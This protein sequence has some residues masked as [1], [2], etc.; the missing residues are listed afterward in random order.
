MQTSLLE[1]AT[2][3]LLL[4]VAVVVGLFLRGGILIAGSRTAAAAAVV[5]AWMAYSG[6]L[7]AQRDAA[8]S[9]FGPPALDP[10]PG[11]GASAGLHRR[12]QSDSARA[13]RNT[14]VTHPSSGSTPSACPWKAFSGGSTGKSACPCR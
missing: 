5:G 1:P 6:I 13:W 9:G 10:H 4:L 7:A 11:A 14:W 8:R 2:L 12:L 3:G